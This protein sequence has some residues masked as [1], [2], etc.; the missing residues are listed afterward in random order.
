MAFELATRHYLF[1]PMADR[2]QA[3][4]SE[5][6]IVYDARHLSLIEKICGEI[7][8]DWA[9]TGQHYEALFRNEELI[10]DM[11]VDERSIGELLRRFDMAADEA[12]D[13]AEFLQPMLAIVPN[14]RPTA[15]EMLQS[16]WL[17]AII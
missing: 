10:V 8:R 5:K 15:R 16:P 6:N 3:E 11:A 1:D 17:H 4:L 9:R 12:N 14:Q 2:S 13:F 7:P